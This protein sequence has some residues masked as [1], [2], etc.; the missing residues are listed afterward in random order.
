MTIDDTG[1]GHITEASPV[2][3]ACTGRYVIGRM[4]YNK[5][6]GIVYCFVGKKAA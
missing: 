3:V 5:K 6:I 1:D 2:H 4:R